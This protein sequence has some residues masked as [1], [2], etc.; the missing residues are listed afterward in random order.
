MVVV[1]FLRVG[2][3]CPRV[4]VVSQV[5]LEAHLHRGMMLATAA[6]YTAVAAI[7]VPEIPWPVRAVFVVPLVILL[8]RGLDPRPAVIIREDS[9]TF[10]GTGKIVVGGDRTY[11]WD[12]IEEVSALRKVFDTHTNGLRITPEAQD[13]FLDRHAGP[14]FTVGTTDGRWASVS[15]LASSPGATKVRQELLSRVAE[16]KS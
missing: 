12:E 10:G 14:K 8:V 4:G 5:V 7:A 9:V 11:G 16:A 15:F 1:P 13:K 6:L 3:C 2:E